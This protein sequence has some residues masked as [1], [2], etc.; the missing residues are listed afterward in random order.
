VG[1]ANITGKDYSMVL[2]ILSDIY[3]YGCRPQYMTRFIITAFDIAVDSDT[4]Q[5]LYGGEMRLDCFGIFYSV[6]RYFRIRATPPFS[7][8]AFPLKYSVFF[9]QMCGIEKDNL[10]YLS[11]RLS[12][13]YLAL[14]TFT[15][16]FR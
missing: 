9:L 11:R 13:V 15:Y 7:F 5:I 10:G 14:V 8:M 6:K 16:Q 12:A 1:L 2:A 4:T 3:T